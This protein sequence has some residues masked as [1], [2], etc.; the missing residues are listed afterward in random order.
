MNIS[1]RAEQILQEMR[2]SRVAGQM[3][4]RLPRAVR[5]RR[6]QSVEQEQA[7]PRQYN[8][9]ITPKQEYF[10]QLVALHSMNHS[11]AYREAYNADNS[12]DSTVWREAS[13]VA[14]NPK[15]WQRIQELR[16]H[17][18][19]GSMVSS[20][21]VFMGA[22]EQGGHPSY[23]EHLDIIRENNEQEQAPDEVAVSNV[24]NKA[25]EP[26]IDWEQELAHVHRTQAELN[27][28]RTGD[29]IQDFL[30]FTNNAKKE[31]AQKRRK[32]RRAEEIG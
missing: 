22:Q 8:T 19:D 26:D 13:I 21:I 11:Q 14:H 15:V 31:K 9:R 10:A 25:M 32:A 24:G 27:Y 6:T 1:E 20:P 16:L 18:I 3:D 23:R 4:N 5:L 17:K 28:P 30:T 29:K 12:L 7:P 2:A